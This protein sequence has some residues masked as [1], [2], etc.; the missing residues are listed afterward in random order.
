MKKSFMKKLL[1]ITLF[2]IFSVSLATK[3]MSN[4]KLSTPDAVTDSADDVIVVDANKR[5]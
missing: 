3:V 4:L 5:N 2:L 1:I